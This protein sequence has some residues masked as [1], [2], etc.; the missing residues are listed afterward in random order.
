MNSETKLILEIWDSF[1]DLIQ[2]SRR[3]DAALSL[4]RIFSEYEM[5]VVHSDLEG[6]DVYLDKAIAAYE[7]DVDEESDEEEF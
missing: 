1:R 6:E 5:D 7:E 3:E 2:S 4:L